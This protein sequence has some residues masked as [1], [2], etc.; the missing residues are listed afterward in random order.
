MKYFQLNKYAQFVL[1]QIVR[2]LLREE[3]LPQADIMRQKI[4]KF[5]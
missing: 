3:V 2:S 1:G 4:E 5:N